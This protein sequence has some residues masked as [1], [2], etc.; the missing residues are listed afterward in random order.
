MIYQLHHLSL[1]SIDA[2]ASRADSCLETAGRWRGLRSTVL[3]SYLALLFPPNLGRLE[4]YV[5]SN[6]A[7]HTIFYL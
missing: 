5:N 7:A 3:T 6:L 4:H 2:Q 1:G